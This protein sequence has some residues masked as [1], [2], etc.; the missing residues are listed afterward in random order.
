[1]SLSWR[2]LKGPFINSCVLSWRQLKG[3]FL[4]SRGVPASPPPAE[5]DA[6]TL[7][8][9]GNRTRRPERMVCVTAG[10]CVLDCGAVCFASFG[11]ARAFAVWPAD[12][13]M[14]ETGLTLSVDTVT[15]RPFMAIRTVFF[16]RVRN[17]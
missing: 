5:N 4:N 11:G 9:A 12:S 8:G 2:T 13:A 14:M 7:N 16:V 15:G 1:M 17:F 6:Q 3:P 10:S